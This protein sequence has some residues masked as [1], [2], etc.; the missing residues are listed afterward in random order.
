MQA[1]HSFHSSGSLL[2]C[3]YP[4]LNKINSSQELTVQNLQHT[5]S[6]IILNLMNNDFQ[7]HRILFS[8]VELISI[9]T[10]FENFYLLSQ[11]TTFLLP[12]R[13]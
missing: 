8:E 9:G 2:H 11:I 13:V 6:S 5:N 7:E 1:P 4:I 12:H 10:P 3:L